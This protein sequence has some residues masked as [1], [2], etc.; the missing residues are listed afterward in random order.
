M[1]FLHATLLLAVLCAW[2]TLSD[3]VDHVGLLPDLLVDRKT[4]VDT[5]EIQVR[6]F[7]ETSHHCAVNEGCVG[8]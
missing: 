2:G 4:L 6:Y 5:L 3:A 7:S 8:G 1:L